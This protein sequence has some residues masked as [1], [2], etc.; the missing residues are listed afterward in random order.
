[1]KKIARL[2][3][4]YYQDLSDLPLF[5][6]AGR[7]AAPPLTLGGRWV[8][9]RVGLPPRMANLVADLAGIGVSYRD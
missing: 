6:W 3:R 8:K 4:D 2:P 1:M 7:A 5:S 9:R